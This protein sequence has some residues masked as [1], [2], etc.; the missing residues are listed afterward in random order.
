MNIIIDKETGN[1]LYK[2]ERFTINSDGLVT[3]KFMDSRLNPDNCEVISLVYR[4][5]RTEERFNSETNELEEVTIPEY[6]P[7]EFNIDWMGGGAIRYQ[8]GQFIVTDYGLTVQNEKLEELRE[9][10]RKQI[11]DARDKSLISKEFTSS[12]G[13]TYPIDLN[14]KNLSVFHQAIFVA[15]LAGLPDTDSYS[16]K[17]ADNKFYSITYGEIKEIALQASVYIQSQFDNEDIKL[18]EI[19][20]ATLTTIEG[21][22]WES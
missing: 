17:M 14:T 7:P 4:P 21:I 11:K 9:Q 3:D 22:T 6:I 13:K 20:A 2:V 8:D 1:V 18:A 16:H 15:G 12:I 10:K 19:D 5:E